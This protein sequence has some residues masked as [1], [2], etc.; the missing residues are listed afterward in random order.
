MGKAKK[1][2]TATVYWLLSCTWGLP[3]TV[4]GAIMALVA[5]CLGGKPE[6]NG[7][8]AIIRIGHGW[9]GVSIGPFALCSEDSGEHTKRHEFGHSL[10]NCIMGPFWPIIVGAPSAI[11]YWV[12]RLRSRRGL[13]NP[14]YDSAWFE[15]TAS[16][17]GDWF[18]GRWDA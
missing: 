14:D 17:W 6:R 18:I 7:P 9:G 1:I 2:A 12:F 3:S 5:L 13:P 11:R 8:T 4:V 10:Q 16:A 15:G